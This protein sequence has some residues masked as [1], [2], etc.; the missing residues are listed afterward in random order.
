MAS[1][2]HPPGAA[3]A[4]RLHWALL[5]VQILFGLWP[6]AGTVVLAYM[7]PPALIGFRLVLGAPILAVAAGLP[8]RPL[9]PAR[10]LG[11][12]A[13]AAALGISINQLL[14]AEGLSRSDP[15]SAAVAIL[16]LTPFTLAIA[17]A[18][19]RER[20]RARRLVGVAIAAAGALV[21][22]RVERLDLADDKL[23]GNLLL[24]VNVL[25][26]A[27]FLVLA[28]PVFQRVGA[29]PG[30]A[31]CFVFGALEALPLTGPALLGVDWVELPPR[32]HLTLAFILAGPT[33]GTYLL[34]A[35]ALRRA[36]SSLVAVYT[37]L[38]PAIAALSAWVVFGTLPEART[39]L[40]AIVILGGITLSR[41]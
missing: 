18:A 10:D 17:I 33:L 28:R 6:V 5:T 14:F 23:V 19:R 31:W 35:W 11:L 38:Q 2:S 27:S 13:V 22:V 3:P 9:P 8:F 7:R 25:A 26:Y 29:L 34:N 4:G 16:L 15:V 12:L 1:R 36:E 41:G 37:N 40:A 30:M 39:L 20:A 32:V 21:L 24:V